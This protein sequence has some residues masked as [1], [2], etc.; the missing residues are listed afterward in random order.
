M[1]RESVER[2]LDYVTR[3]LPY[4]PSDQVGR[5]APSPHVRRHCDK[6][7]RQRRHRHASPR[8]Y[9]QRCRN[10]CQGN[11]LTVDEARGQGQGL[12]HRRELSSDVASGISLRP[13]LYGHDTPTG[14]ARSERALVP[15]RP[16]HLA[17]CRFNWPARW[18]QGIAHTLPR[19]VEVASSPLA[20]ALLVASSQPRHHQERRTNQQRYT[21][22]NLVDNTDCRNEPI[23]QQFHPTGH[24]RVG[25]V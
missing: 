15:Q 1:V 12:R 4:H 10:L 18:I 19:V 23:P 9:H 21:H 11:S 24:V 3:A 22:Q 17:P 6:D 5:H 20:R 7:Y 16:I 8:N 25:K 14:E 13:P 2:S